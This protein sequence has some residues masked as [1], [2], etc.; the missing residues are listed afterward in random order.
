[1]NAKLVRINADYPLAYKEFV[2]ENTIS[3]MSRGL[4]ALKEIDKK[5]MKLTSEG[6]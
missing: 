4:H 1:M 3:I 2:S 6:N 5:I